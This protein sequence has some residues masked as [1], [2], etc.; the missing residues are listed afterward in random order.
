MEMT[1][2][3]KMLIGVLCLG[4]GGLAVDRFILGAPESAAADD[5]IITIQEPQT[6]STLQPLAELNPGPEAP[7]EAPKALPSYASL[8]Q[9][10]IQAKAQAGDP[11]LAGQ[12]ADPFALPEQWQSAKTRPRQEEPLDPAEKEHVISGVF[13]LDGTVR[14]LI[15]EREELLAVI[16][17]GGLDGRAIRLGQVVHVSNDRGSHDKYQL[18]EI[19]TRYVVWLALDGGDRIRMQVEED[20]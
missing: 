1:K 15:D 11:T 4:L 2:Q 9:R 14:S 19:G 5:E 7:G 16:S 3:R 6:P 17:G 10:L 12:Q 8:T 13:K 18:V 20:L